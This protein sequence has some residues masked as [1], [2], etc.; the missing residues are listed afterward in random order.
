MRSK[1]KIIPDKRIRWCQVTSRWV[2][3]GSVSVVESVSGKF[4][5]AGQIK[6]EAFITKREA[7]DYL[8]KAVAEDSVLQ[9]LPTIVAK[10][11]PPLNPPA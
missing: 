8:V 2:A 10:L 3:E 4:V 6:T 5:G 1:I 7:E 9:W 11:P